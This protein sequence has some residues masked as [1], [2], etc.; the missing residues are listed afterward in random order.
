MRM[1]VSCETRTPPTRRPGVDRQQMSAGLSP[2][3]SGSN[4]SMDPP[5]VISPVPLCVIG[6]NIL[7][8][9]QSNPPPPPDS[10]GGRQRRGAHTAPPPPPQPR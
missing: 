1:G 10:L 5:V 3:H 4:R 6:M 7:N 9:W 2:A 8:S